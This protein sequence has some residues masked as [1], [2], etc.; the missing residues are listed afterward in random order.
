TSMADSE[1]A[2][3]VAGREALGLRRMIEKALDHQSA[4]SLDRSAPK[5]IDA[6][7]PKPLGAARNPADVVTPTFN[8]N[9]GESH[10]HDL[11]SPVNGRIS[12]KFGVRPDPWTGVKR[13]HKGLDIAAPVGTPVK[14]AAAGKVTFSGWAEGYGRLVAIDHGDGT[15]TRYGHNGLNMVQAGDEVG[16]GQQIALVGATGRVTG[17]HLHFEVE[18]NG[19]VVDPSEVIDFKQ[20]I[21][22]TEEQ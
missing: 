2:R 22:K 14:A 17:P 3:A 11:D 13:L 15:V 16:A 12:S 7:A 5:D 1:V 4:G 21:V 10:A 20:V 8:S 9:A 6:P 19:E 18:R